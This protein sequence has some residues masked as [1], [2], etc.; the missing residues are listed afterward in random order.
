ML[1]DKQFLAVNI[2]I[3]A[4]LILFSAISSVLVFPKSYFLGLI[5]GILLGWIV[6]VVSYYRNYRENGKYISP[7]KEE[8]YYKAGAISFWIFMVFGV[9]LSL[10]MRAE[11]VNLNITLKDISSLVVK[12]CLATYFVILA[13]LQQREGASNG[14]AE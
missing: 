8:L 6:Y 10:L 12:V 1:K 5:A 2:V 11:N 3:F 9:I 4:I 7:I 14:K 13:I